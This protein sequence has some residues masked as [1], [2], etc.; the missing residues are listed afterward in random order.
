[1]QKQDTKTGN[2]PQIE[3]ESLARLLLPQVREYFES[4]DGNC[5]VEK[6]EELEVTGKVKTSA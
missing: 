4:K 3:I 1:M 5:E 2:I 6:A